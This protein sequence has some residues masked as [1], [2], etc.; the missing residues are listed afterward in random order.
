ML[1]SQPSSPRFTPRPLILVQRARV[2]SL[3]SEVENL[4]RAVEQKALL[5]KR[6]LPSLPPSPRSEPQIT[7][8]KNGRPLI[9]HSPL[10]SYAI[11]SIFSIFSLDIHSIPLLAITN[12]TDDPRKQ[13]NVQSSALPKAALVSTNPPSS[14]TSG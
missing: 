5:V 13:P 1:S 9:G 6:S 2:S 8:L 12:P 14:G 3:N 10:E 7:Y 11:V 4:T